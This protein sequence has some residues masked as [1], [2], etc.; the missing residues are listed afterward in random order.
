M[1]NSIY[2]KNTEVLKNKFNLQDQEK[3]NQMERLYTTATLSELKENPIK[4]DFD[5]KH[6]QEI[7]K[8]IF[9][10][11]YEWAGKTRNFDISKGT[12]FC[13]LQHLD[14]YQND[15]FR[16]LKKENNLK[17]LD[18]DQFSKRAAH[19]L[20][21]INMIHP[22]LEGNGRTQRE[23][24]RELALN[25]GYELRLD[26]NGI[27][28]EKMIEAS[29][30]SANGYN[31]QFE[32][33]IRDNIKPIELELQIELPKGA[34]AKTPTSWEVKRAQKSKDLYDQYAK[35]AVGGNNNLDKV[36]IKNMLKKEIDE[37][38]IIGAMKNSPSLSG[39][40]AITKSK[41]IRAL[42]QQVKKEYPEITRSKGYER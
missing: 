27:S 12:M 39:L 42:M 21:E 37:Q 14:S 41:E 1:S 38:T 11:V 24:M 7:H 10:D 9:K 20:G 16:G 3:L 18:I 23:F 8:T 4:G 6:L 28:R 33:I 13:P 32:K 15:V 17:G 30:R 31:D 35:E 19:Y 29:I 26:S 2:Y 25:A 5:M 40:S 22:F 34:P 36:M